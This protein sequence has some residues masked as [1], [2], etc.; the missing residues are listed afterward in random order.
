LNEQ[1]AKKEIAQAKEELLEAK[2][3]LQELSAKLKDLWDVMEK[4]EAAQGRLQRVEEKLFLES[5]GKKSFFDRIDNK[6]P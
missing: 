1:E 6:K 4:I 5:F 3:K 2:A